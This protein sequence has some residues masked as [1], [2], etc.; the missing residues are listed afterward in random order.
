MA[1]HLLEFKVVSMAKNNNTAN[2]SFVSWVVHVLAILG[3]KKD[4]VI[5]DNNEQCDDK[6]STMNQKLRLL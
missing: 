5:I 6:Y 3:Q 1:F 4:R 2:D